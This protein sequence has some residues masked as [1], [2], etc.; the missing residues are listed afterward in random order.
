[1]SLPLGFGGSKL[2]LE[3]DKAVSTALLNPISAVCVQCHIVWPWYREGRLFCLVRAQTSRF[4]FLF[5][6]KCKGCFCFLL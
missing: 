3:G 6:L 5:C 2:L 4:Y 1:M